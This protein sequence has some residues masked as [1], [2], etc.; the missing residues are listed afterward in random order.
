MTFPAK[1]PRQRAPSARSLATRARI[2]DAA[3]RLFAERGYEG[4]S[5]RDIAAAAGTTAGLVGFHGGAKHDLFAAVIA[6][7][8]DELAAL[9]LDALHGAGA[10]L[11]DVLAASLGPL[12]DKA[13]HGGPQW[14]AYAR[15]MAVVSADPAWRAI[16][17]AHFD[18]VS[19]RFVDEIARLFPNASRAAAAEAYVFAVSACLA[20]CT[21]GWRAEAL[22][23]APSRGAGLNGL[24]DFCEGGT[25][26][27]LSRGDA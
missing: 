7:R 24:L 27:A 10:D 18:P 9:R 6:R 26:M 13:M 14:Q 17:E 15:L 23:R 21:A 11:R 20:A 25:R 3:E 16:S 19:A 1:R 12:F 4:A 2:F 8:A 22:S 5:V